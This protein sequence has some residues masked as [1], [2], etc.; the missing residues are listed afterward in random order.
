MKDFVQN[1]RDNASPPVT[2]SDRHITVVMGM[3]AKKSYLEHSICG[4]ILP[5]SNGDLFRRMSMRKRNAG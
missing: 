1:I 4:K 3:A 2:G 5:L